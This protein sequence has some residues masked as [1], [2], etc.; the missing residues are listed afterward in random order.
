M[1]DIHSLTKRYGRT[2]AVEDLTFTVRPGRVTAF[3]GPNGAGKSTTLRLLLGL[4][5]PDRGRALIGGTPYPRLRQPL[6]HVGALLDAR[7]LQRTRTG[8][9]HLR[10]LAHTHRIGRDRVEHVLERA[11]I[12]DAADRPAGGYSLGMAQRLGIAAALLGD[13]HTLI[14]DEPVNGLDPHGIRWIRT[15]LR[16]LAAEGRTVLLSSHLMGE[17]ALTADQLVIV[18]R[19]RLVEDLPLAEFTTRHGGGSLEEAF[20]ALTED[21]RDH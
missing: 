7:A 4:D 8:R 18:S 10:W 2:T 6:R 17:T 16:D 13:P 21:H 15:L 12:A 1:I 9:D 11:G 19:G 14:L 5:R 20:L 3:L